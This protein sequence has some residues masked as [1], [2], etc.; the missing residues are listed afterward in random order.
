M[1][2]KDW[3][4]KGQELGASD[5]HLES[6]VPLV[7]RIRGDLAAVG[8]PIPAQHVTQ[9]GQELLGGEVWAQFLERGSADAS[10]EAGACG[11]A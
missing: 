8:E 2:L 11:A 3:I 9:V 7:V 4:Q 5:L 10:V 1:S 6:G